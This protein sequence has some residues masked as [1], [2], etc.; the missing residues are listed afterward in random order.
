VALCQGVVLIVT[1]APVSFSGLGVM[2]MTPWIST[3]VVDVPVTP[4]QDGESRTIPAV[5]H[6]AA[7][8]IWA[9][10]NPNGYAAIAQITQPTL[11]VNGSRDIVI[12]TIN[13]FILQ[14]HIPNAKLVLYPDSGHG[15]HYEYHEDFVVQVRLFLAASES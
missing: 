3:R 13:S 12:D 14:Q 9:Q 8:A 7:A 11:V 6:R 10:P 2:S 15:A 1:F 4:R 5:A